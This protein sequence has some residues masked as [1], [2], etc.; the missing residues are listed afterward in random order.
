MQLATAARAA[1]AGTITELL[2]VTPRVDIAWT[3]DGYASDQLIGTWP[4][5]A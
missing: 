3:P 5:R 1:G 4:G 2:G